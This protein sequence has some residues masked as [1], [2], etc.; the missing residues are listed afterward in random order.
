M[1]KIIIL[2]AGQQG[3]TCKRLAEEN[4]YKVVAFVDDFKTGTVECVPIYSDI[5]D[6]PDHRECKFIVAIGNIG[7]RKR[8]RFQID[9]LNLETVNL[10]DKEAFIEEGAEIGT[11]NFIG[12]EA[13]IYSSA[14]VGNDNIINCK[15]VVATD[16]IIGDNCNISLGCNICGGV[17]VGDNCYV[18]CQASIV[19]GVKVGNGAT[20]GAGSV[21]LRDV[22]DGTFVAGIPVMKKNRKEQ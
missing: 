9:K 16:A 5:R 19:S 15:A 22:E 11:G 3:R 14:K 12:K 8:Q 21:V 13:I 1:D 4:G 7:P 2:G 20:V 18:G 17:E 6:I 10:I